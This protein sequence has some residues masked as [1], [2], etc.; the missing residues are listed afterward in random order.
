MRLDV[1][2]LMEFYDTPLGVCACRAILERVNGLWGDMNGLDVLGIGYTPPFL[3]RLTGKPRRMTSLMPASQGGH[4]WHWRDAGSSSVLAAEDRMPFPDALFD[5]VLI[6]HAL[7]ETQN[8]TTFLREVWR[9]SA[10]EARIIV[11]VPN[12]SGVWSLSD[13]TPFGYGRPFSRRQ[14][15]RLMRDALI[16]PSAWTRTLY[17]PPV[18]WKIFTSSS[19][20]WERTGEMFLASLGG[21]NLV[22]GIKRVQIDPNRPEKARIV[23][24]Q[25]ARPVINRKSDLHR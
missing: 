19:E 25:R 13:A 12:R 9:V 21:V 5:R 23:V 14:L 18:D 6:I 8:I 10:P 3:D 11:I 15:K 7:E 24:P 20:G 1:T 17:T 2:D 22:E 16:E 4:S